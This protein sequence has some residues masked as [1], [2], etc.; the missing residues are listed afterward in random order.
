MIRA[1]KRQ[2]LEDGPS[3]F[4]RNGGPPGSESSRPRKQSSIDNLGA[5]DRTPAEEQF[6]L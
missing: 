1:W 4:A 5:Q 6:V 3:V 2:L